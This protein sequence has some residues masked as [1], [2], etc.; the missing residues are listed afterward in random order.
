[1]VCLP[2][3]WR[4]QWMGGRAVL[5]LRGYTYRRGAPYSYLGTLATTRRAFQN[6]MGTCAGSLMLVSY[7]REAA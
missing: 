5:A 7:A 6:V 2:G 3:S 1:M 4:G